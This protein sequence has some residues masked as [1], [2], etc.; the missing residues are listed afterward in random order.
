MKKFTD[1]IRL[2]IGVDARSLAVF[3]ICI[4]VILLFDL[5]TRVLSMEAHYS[6]LGVISREVLFAISKTPILL[7]L[8]TFSGDLI[9][10]WVVFGV[11]TIAAFC[12]LIGFRTQLATIVCAIMY[13]SI[14]AR[15][16]FITNSGDAYLLVLLYWG[17][18]LPL[19]ARF[20]L[21]ARLNKNEYP[22]SNQVFSIATLGVIIQIFV[23]YFFS[24]FAKI[25]PVWHTEWT[26]IT[27]ALSLDRFATPIGEWLLLMPEDVL[28]A[29]TVATLYLERWGA[30]MVFLPVFI[31]PTRV[32]L[33]FIF[34]SFH[35]GLG[36]SMTL[37]LFPLVCISAWLIL[38]PGALWDNLGYR[39]RNG[40]MGD[41][42]LSRKRSPLPNSEE[43]V[44]VSYVWHL[45]VST[46]L[47]WVVVSSNLLSAGQMSVAY[48]EAIYKYVEPLVNSLHMGQKWTM[49][50]PH[51]PKEDGWVLIVGILNDGTLIDLSNEGERVSWKRPKDI[52]ATYKNQRWRKNMEYV[53][54]KWDPHARLMGDY[55][56]G[57]WNRVHAGKNEV[58]GVI[59]YS[60]QE[61]TLDHQ[62]SSPVQ[63]KVLYKSKTQ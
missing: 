25:S 11:A 53:M 34:I 8:N 39:F 5:R 23:L 36:L 43:A 28:K 1:R 37:G 58:M 46:L 38:V 30:L 20:S 40:R 56:M 21:D 2:L 10:Q 6:D 63:R 7:S 12:L 42:I 44:T 24:V 4:G 62:R 15:N 22:I 57:R 35:I 45:L 55:F 17:I 33:V 54:T 60:M 26:A 19:G 47:L 59:V 32:L 29:G 3:R 51:P 14:H 18:L 31:I 16:P 48:Y 61:F 41:W 13:L 27:Y 50:A 9:W 52:S 49:F